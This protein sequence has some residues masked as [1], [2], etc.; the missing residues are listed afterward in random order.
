MHLFMKETKV[1]AEVSRMFFRL[2]FFLFVFIP[3]S[4]ALSGAVVL[5]NPGT[6]CL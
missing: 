4:K 1:D 6:I 5:E 2:K 3:P